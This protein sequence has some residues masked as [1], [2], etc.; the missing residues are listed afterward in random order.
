MTDDAVTDLVAEHV[1]RMAGIAPLAGGVALDLGDA[2]ILIRG[3]AVQLVPDAAEADCRVRLGREV[4]QQILD[5]ERD[6]FEAFLS[7][8]IAT[9]GDM[10]VAVQLQPLL[11][12]DGSP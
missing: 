8:D 7:G 9:D 5:G 11:S 1:T 2:C 10:S 12:P 4:L 3:R 6:A